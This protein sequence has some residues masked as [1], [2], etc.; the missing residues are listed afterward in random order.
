MI[1]SESEKKELKT[2][3]AN[4]LLSS[5]EIE[6]IIVFGSFLESKSPNDI[7]IAIFQ[8]SSDNYLTLALK[9]RKMIRDISKKIPVDVIPIRSGASNSFLMDEIK[10]ITSPEYLAEDN[11][12][13]LLR[14]LVKQ[15]EA[16]GEHRSPRYMDHGSYLPEYRF[17]H[18]F[19]S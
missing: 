6:K 19:R 11:A 17:P 18:A 10:R 7:D 9:Y 14:G 4:S 3:I 16:A 13:L 1:L 5:S 8:N 12:E 2:N 15:I